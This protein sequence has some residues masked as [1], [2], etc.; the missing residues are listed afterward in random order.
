MVDP[1]GGT[2]PRWGL[3]ST[4]LAVVA[5]IVVRLACSTWNSQRRKLR[6]VAE[7]GM[8]M[9]ENPGAGVEVR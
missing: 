1:F 7:L 6:Q 5:P 3:R 8:A 4:T 2:M 9:V